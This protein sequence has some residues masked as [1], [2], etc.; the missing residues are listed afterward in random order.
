VKN[1]AGF[2]FPKLMVGSLGQL[3][4]I[5]EVTFKVFPRP[6]AYATYVVDAPTLNV[7]LELQSRLLMAP[8]DLG[9]RSTW[10]RS[11]S[12]PVRAARS[13]R[14]GWAVWPSRCRPGSGA[15]VT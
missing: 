13:S 2:D 14:C 6:R 10:R 5:V 4:A 8:L 9:R 12:R 11:I 1:A 7:A 3:G 15:C